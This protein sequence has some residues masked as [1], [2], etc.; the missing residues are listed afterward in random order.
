MSEGLL[1][2][3]LPPVLL[4]MFTELRECLCCFPISFAVVL[5][6]CWD[7]GI[8]RNSRISGAGFMSLCIGGCGMWGVAARASGSTGE[9][10]EVT[11]T[12]LQ[13]DP[14]IF[15]PQ[16]GVSGILSVWYI[17]RDWL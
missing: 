4:C 12:P 14:R 1:S 9:G 15:R 17:C 13:K 7:W 8:G 6:R 2:C 11:H 16:S 10:E 3:L 5:L